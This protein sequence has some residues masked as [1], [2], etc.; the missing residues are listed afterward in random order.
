MVGS[1]VGWWQDAVA[2]GG[3]QMNR[4]QLLL[5]FGGAAGAGVVGTSAFS[6][7]AADRE[8]SV[9]VADDASAFIG[10]TPSGGPNGEF[11]TATDAGQLELGFGGTETGGQGLGAR[12]VYTFD[13]VFEIRNRGT[14]TIYVWGS[15]DFDDSSFGP[16]DVYFYPESD[17]GERLRNGEESVLAL[18]VGERES[19]GVHID[20][21]AV[22]TDQTL[23]V[24]INAN[25]DK[26][27]SSNAVDRGEIE[28]QTVSSPDGSIDV[29][30][31]VSSG[32]PEYSV[33]YDG[34]TYLERSPIGFNFDGQ[35][36]FGTAIE[37]TGP[38]VVAT[39]SERGTATETWMP[40]WGSF[41][42]VAE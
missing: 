28:T 27:E 22:D 42:S 26:P 32:V 4:R 40:E 17:D 16:E 33:D 37:G 14:Q 34:T 8:V 5:L 25:T 19:I 23:S 9:S 29:T 1:T 35:Q 24:T 11:A 2:L 41:E 13:D 3:H 36:A 6:N 10:L 18:G 39:A 21:D 12:S 20:T 7:V 15:F 30:V 31:D 38:A